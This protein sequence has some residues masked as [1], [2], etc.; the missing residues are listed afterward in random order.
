[1]TRCRAATTG[2]ALALL[3]IVGLA[4]DRIE[5]RQ[6]VANPS[7]KQTGRPAASPV[8]STSADPNTIVVE[9]PQ[10][11]AM[12]LETVEARPFRVTKTATGRI[13]FNE[14]TTTP[15]FT[16]FTGRIVRL[17]AKPGDEV[18]R[19]AS[20]VEID[21][22]DL[23]QV[24][25]DLIAAS[26]AHVKA[27]NQ[28]DLATRTTARQKELYE[29]QAVSK[30]D[31]EIAESELRNAETDVR[32]TTGT[33]TAVRDRLRIYGKREEDIVRIE[34]THQIDRVSQVFAPIGGT[35]TARK[36]GPG[37][38]VKTDNP[39][40]L[41]TIADLSTMWLLANVY[42]TD[43]PLIRV[44]QMLEVRVL[45]YPSEIFRARVSYI[46]AA[47]DPTTH[48][49]AVRAEVANTGQRLKPE[50]FASFVILTGEETVLPTVPVAAVVR[51]GEAASVW[52][53]VGRDRF[54]R[55]LVELGAEDGG[56]VQ[57]RS[58]L[59][60]GER[61]ASAGALFLSNAWRGTR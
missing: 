23:V 12:R 59:K 3:G 44:G 5:E 54:V 56:T 30:K 7:A 20:L 60:P 36:V 2:L 29:A 25:S 50:M 10:L 41:Y 19:G 38:F 47:A 15:V 48:R 8:P 18:Q 39:D 33:L 28:L 40:P 16:P 22:P 53:A 6:A 49:V 32:G 51:D 14:D 21:T 11:R 61:V 42:E 46:G 43:I 52:V 55:R 26:A 58:G 34:G 31:L 37:Q 45:A 1:M 13:A 35:V 4:C 57:V 24:E 9:E 17:L 27:R